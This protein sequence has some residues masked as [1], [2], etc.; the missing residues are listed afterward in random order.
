[1]KRCN[2]TIQLR[3]GRVNVCRRRRA[4]RL[5]EPSALSSRRT[6]RSRA[7]RRARR[8][9]GQA[10]DCAEETA[11]ARSERKC[12]SKYQNLGTI[13]V[14]HP[15]PRDDR[16]RPQSAH[17]FQPPPV[18][19]AAFPP[20]RNPDAA[21]ALKSLDSAKSPVSLPLRLSGE[22]AVKRSD[23]FRLVSPRFASL[24][25]I[26][27]SAALIRRGGQGRT[28]T[29]SARTRPPHSPFIL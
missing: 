1:M 27:P 24:R 28:S 29:L 20:R 16:P 26:S 4:R 14:R 3:S 25:L 22:S 11:G 18:R 17:P 10:A 2:E 12:L 13:V 9:I 6:L 15:R 21:N 23:R 19:P 5:A 7:E 8:P